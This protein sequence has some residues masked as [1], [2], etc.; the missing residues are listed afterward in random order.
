MLEVLAEMYPQADFFALF[1]RKECLPA[2]LKN[3]KIT[4]SFLDRIPGAKRMYRHLLPLYPFA[5]ECLDLSGYDLVISA[6]GAAT[7]GVLTDQHALH[8]C[9]CH[10]PP[11]SF[12]DQYAAFRR[13]MSWFSRLLFTPVSQYLRLWDFSAA[14]RIDGFIANSDYVKNRIWK[15]YR[16][17]STVI[18][19]PV[20]TSAAYLSKRPASYYLCVGRLI[21]A[22]RVDLLISACNRL[23]RELR[24]VGVGPEEGALRTLAGSSVKFLGRLTESELL[25]AYANCWAL[26]F[27]ADEDCGLVAIE[28]QACGR[29]IIAYGRGGSRETV[30]GMPPETYRGIGN[31]MDGS[32]AFT[33]VF[34]AE[35]TTLSVETAI[36]RF[37]AIEGSFNPVEIQ[38][39]AATFDTTVFVSKFLSYVSQQSE[40]RHKH[41]PTVVE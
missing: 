27:A 20:D 6:D 25:H 13:E 3:R 35:Q 18:Y 10:S 24:I 16:R 39:H 1:V 29:P 11:H 30:I 37:E 17:E 34:F 22:K 40:N 5:V 38:K 28:A 31:S 23:G 21:A 2:K 15:Y 19:P 9:Y 41:S 33:G 32:T 7:K 4:T 12:W 14:Q 36:Q 26:L 8:L